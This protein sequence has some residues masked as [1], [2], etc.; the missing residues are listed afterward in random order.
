M[1]PFGYVDV[2]IQFLIVTR[3]T[4]DR[5]EE[6]R[7]AAGLSQ[8]RLAALLGVK[9]QQVSAWE[10][11]TRIPDK[12]RAG[13]A[14]ALGIGLADLLGWI[15]DDERAKHDVVRRELTQTLQVVD[16]F[17]TEFDELR[18][19]LDRMLTIMEKVSTQQA[20]V[21]RLLRPD[22]GPPRRRA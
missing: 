11:G 20:E 7:A 6:A 1:I 15:A 5:I 2:R 10:R 19:S 14:D 17:V 13:L 12:H 18:R 16:R 22:D 8:P 21:L 9:Q 4:G 3:R